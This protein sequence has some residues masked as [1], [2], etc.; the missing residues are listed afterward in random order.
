MFKTLLRFFYYWYLWST[1]VLFVIFCTTF[2]M[3]RRSYV[4]F[5]PKQCLKCWSIIT[6]LTTA[7]N[8]GAAAAAD[9][10][11]WWWR[12]YCREHP[13]SLHHQYFC[14]WSYYS[15]NIFLKEM[16]FF[17]YHKPTY[18]LIAQQCFNINTYFS[19]VWL[20]QTTWAPLS[21]IHSQSIV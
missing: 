15:Y 3:L 12:R 11:L 16:M 21:H 1:Q 19:W 5:V 2:E 4:S 13:A 17:L 20:W 8:D 9:G 6:A 10:D 18:V 7:P 14:H